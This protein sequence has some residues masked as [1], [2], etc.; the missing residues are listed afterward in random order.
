MFSYTSESM[1]SPR[2][3]TNEIVRAAYYEPP[4]SIQR[5]KDPG[6]MIYMLPQGHVT[7][8]KGSEVPWM[9][10]MT[11]FGAVN[12]QILV[13]KLGVQTVCFVVRDESIDHLFFHCPVDIYVE[14]G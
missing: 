5:R 9:G 8:I 7:K 14:I 13:S 3:W 11:P 10:N 2:R 6:V 4:V 12:K 1:Q